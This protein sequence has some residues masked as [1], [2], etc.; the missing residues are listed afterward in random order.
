[1]QNHPT[2]VLREMTNKRM[3][4]ASE[5]FHHAHLFHWMTEEE[6]PRE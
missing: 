6:E 5:R 4:F 3:M 2:R 1:M